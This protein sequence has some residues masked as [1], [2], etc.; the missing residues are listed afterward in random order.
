MNERISYV[1]DDGNIGAKPISLLDRMLGA[2]LAFLGIVFT[3][4]LAPVIL[5]LEIRAIAAF[6]HPFFS[7]RLLAFF[8]WG[9]LWIV[10][11]TVAGWIAG[12]PRVLLLFSYIW[13]TADPP[14]RQLSLGLWCAIIIVCAFTSVAMWP[15]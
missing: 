9:A 4:A 6:Q 12:F 2:M 5:S 8:I 3:L 1:D 15:F 10:P 11:A 13:F 14:N 7:S